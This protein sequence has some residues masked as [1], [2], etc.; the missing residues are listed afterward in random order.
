[1]RDDGLFYLDSRTSAATVGAA[2]AKK[3]GV[4][5]YQRDVFLDN[6]QNQAAI[7]KQLR[8]AENIA[9][10]RGHAIAIGHPHKQTLAALKQWLKEKDPSVHVVAISTLPPL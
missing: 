10:Q 9:K 4:R 8:Q 1:M 3:L 2:E 6:E 5:T 7:L